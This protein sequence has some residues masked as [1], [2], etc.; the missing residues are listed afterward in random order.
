[1]REREAGVAH[2]GLVPDVRLSFAL[3]RRSDENLAKTLSFGRQCQC[4]IAAPSLPPYS[5]LTLVEG[6][7][8]N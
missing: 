8:L 7:S 6:R 1:M 2:Q 5:L 3:V 4:I